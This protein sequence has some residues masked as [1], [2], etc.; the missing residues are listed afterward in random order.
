M[1]SIVILALIKYLTSI[2]LELFLSLL[3]RIS[4][5]IIVKFSISSLKLR[6]FIIVKT[7]LLIRRIAFYYL[8]KL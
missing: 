3:I 8:L 2:Y 6:L 1:L 5:S 4:L 7:K